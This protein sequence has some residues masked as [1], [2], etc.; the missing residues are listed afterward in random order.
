MPSPDHHGIVRCPQ[1]G[2]EFTVDDWNDL[3]E[4]LQF[5]R[6][7]IDAP[8]HGLDNLLRKHGRLT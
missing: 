6:H 2:H 3:L 1:C 5:L 4:T 7:L 8:V